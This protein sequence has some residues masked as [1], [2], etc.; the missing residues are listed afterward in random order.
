MLKRFGCYVNGRRWSQPVAATNKP[1]L[2]AAGPFDRNERYAYFGKKALN[3][4]SESMLS[5]QLLLSEV[6]SGN[7]ASNHEKEYVM[8]KIYTLW[9]PCFHDRKKGRR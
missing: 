7:L 1:A 2:F 3:W 9:R 8:D 5:Q 6:V 4:P